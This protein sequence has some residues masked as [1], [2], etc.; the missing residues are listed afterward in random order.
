MVPV[1]LGGESLNPIYAPCIYS[2]FTHDLCIGIIGGRPKHSLY[3]VGFQE[4][5][6]IHLDP[7]LCQDAVAVTQT[8][9]SP[10]S[11]HCSSPRKMALS[12]MDPSA[13]LGFYCHSRTQFLRLMEELPELVT[14]KEPGFEYPIFEFVDGSCPDVD[15]CTRQDQYRALSR[16]TRTLLGRDK[17]RCGRRLAK[18]VEGHLNANDLRPA[19]RVL[20]KLRLKSL[21]RACAI[22]AADGHLVL[23]MDGQ[24]AR[25][26][27]HFGQLFTVDPPTGQLHTTG[28]QAVDADPPIDETAP[29]LDEVREAVAKLSGG[30]AAGVC[31]IVISVWSFSK[32]GVKP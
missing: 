31:K 5:S 3:F 11:Y 17:E 25:W 1:R 15:A 9:F 18:D 27:E 24:M 7:H 20:K 16:R 2:L 6:L 14:P 8:V 22:R 13:T 12:R 26:A 4:E 29:S 19:Y 23:D 21:S 28:L 32:L 10:S 30:K